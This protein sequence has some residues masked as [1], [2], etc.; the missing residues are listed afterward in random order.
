MILAESWID[1][2]FKSFDYFYTR[3]LFS[4]ALILGVSSLLN[5]SENAGDLEDFKLC[6]QLLKK[7]KDSGSLPAMEFYQHLEALKTS[8]A[9]STGARVNS[10]GSTM[11]GTP[12]AAS[13]PAALA[14]PVRS[15]STCP[16]MADMALSEPCLEAFLLE[17]E[18]GLDPTDLLDLSQLEGLYWPMSDV[19]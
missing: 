6:D 4:T 12:Q 13:A 2:S 14:E 11:L 3:Y 15:H 7:L 1:G 5:N 10:D 16:M 8:L 18:P 9:T 17:S 19:L